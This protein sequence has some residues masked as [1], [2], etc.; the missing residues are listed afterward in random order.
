MKYTFII[1]NNLLK[2]SK[3]EGEVSE[4]EGVFQVR[5]E[6]SDVWLFAP[7]LLSNLLSYPEDRGF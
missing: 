1:R 3:G 6:G 2:L 5:V 7:H 4:G